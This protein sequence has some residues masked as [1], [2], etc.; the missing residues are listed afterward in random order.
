MYI[1]LSDI[2]KGTWYLAVEEYW[3]TASCLE[4][5]L[6]MLLFSNLSCVQFFANPCYSHSTPGSSVLH[7]LLEFA[8]V[9]VHWVCDSIQPFHPLSGPFFLPSIFPRIRVFSNESAL[10]IRWPKYW[11]FTVSN[12]PSNGHSG[13]FPLG[14]TGLISLL[15][16]RLLRVFSNITIW[17]NQFFSAQPCSWPNSHIHMWLLG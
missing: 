14:L 15:S 17:N 2:A 13:W 16:K 3:E 1:K 8:Q 5:I 10:H 6:K 11:N 12:S 7:S 4:M 9:H